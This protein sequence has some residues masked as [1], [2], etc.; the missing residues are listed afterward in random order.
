MD[1]TMKPALKPA[2]KSALKSTAKPASASAKVAAQ[3]VASK[4]ANFTLGKTAAMDVFTFFDSHLKLYSAHSN[5]RGI[6]FLGDG[7][8]QAQRKAMWGMIERG[9][10]AGK[11]TVER[12]AAASASDT[13]YHHGVGSLEGTIVGLAQDFAGSNNMN[14]LCPEGQFG[15]RLDKRPSASRYIKTQ[16]HENFRKLYRKEDDAIMQFNMSSGD[17]IE[18]KFFIPILPTVLINGAQGMGTGHATMIMSYNPTEIKEAVLK[19]LA[20]KKLSN[21]DLTPWFNGFKGEVCRDKTTGQVSTK[22]KLTI[23]NAT[24]IKITELPVGMESDPYETKLFKLQDKGLITDFDNQWDDGFEITVKVPRSTTAKT[25]E[26]LYKIFSLVSK[27]SENFT[28]WSTDGYIRKFEA[29]EEMISEFVNWRLA[30]YD[31]RLLKQIADTNTDI[32][33]S[34]MKI[35]F[36]K[37]YLKNIMQFKNSGKKELVQMLIE[38]DFAEYDRLLS[39]SI[40]NLT[41]DKIAELEKELDEQRAAL[42]VLEEDSASKMYARE[43]KEFKYTPV[44]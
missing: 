15:S 1:K 42:K 28:V 38:N 22:G 36:I 5:V 20:G 4:D 29:P 9:E 10:N 19:L 11:N 6:P 18:P 31:T 3:K 32:S 40:W 12:I 8:K 37:F 13:D 26:E 39:M 44:N 43:L 30:M 16:L 41:K 2:L 14:L 17:K 24:T 34:S 35:R 7:F 25:E 23:V 27:D 21:Y 33:W